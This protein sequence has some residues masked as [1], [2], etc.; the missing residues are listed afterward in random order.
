MCIKGPN[1]CKGYL[2]DPEKTAEALDEDGW[3]HTGDIGKWLPVSRTD[4]S[5]MDRI[6]AVVGR[7]MKYWCGRCCRTARWRSLTGRRI[8]SRWR[9]VNTSPRRRSKWS[10][11][12]VNQ[13]PR[14]LFTGTVYRSGIDEASRSDEWENSRHWPASH[15]CIFRRALLA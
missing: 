5:A 3:L 14:Y 15:L 10:I 4:S 9:R 8:F 6:N 12:S 13:W 1:V 7:C 2:N 11:I